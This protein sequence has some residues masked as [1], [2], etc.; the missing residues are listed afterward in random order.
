MLIL[1]VNEATTFT[2]HNDPH[3]MM[4][5]AL[6]TQLCSNH[7]LVFFCFK[8]YVLND[9]FCQ[10]LEQSSVYITLYQFIPWHKTYFWS[11][12]FWDSLTVGVLEL[13]WGT[14]HCTSSLHP[15][16]VV[17]LPWN[18]APHHSDCLASQ[19]L[20]DHS[21]YPKWGYLYN[22][23]CVSYQNHEAIPIVLS[24]GTLMILTVFL[25]RT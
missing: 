4:H 21:N 5:D 7:I 12:N 24:E 13:D 11:S 6:D 10:H 16:L 17:W 18:E 15:N 3:N 22:F 25:V 8:L 23:D 9:I 1:E 19:N 14:K 2:F 20:G